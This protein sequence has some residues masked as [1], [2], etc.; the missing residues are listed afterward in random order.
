[1]RGLKTWG[2]VISVASIAILLTSGGCSLFPK[3]TEYNPSSILKTD[4]IEYSFAYAKRGDLIETASVVCAYMAIDKEDY[5]FEQ[6]GRQYSGI[7][8]NVGDT[9]EKG[10][11]LAELDMTEIKSELDIREQKRKTLELDVEFLSREKELMVEKNNILIEQASMTES[12]NLSSSAEIAAA[13]DIEIRDK[14]YELEN[15]NNEI[16][17]LRADIESGRLYARMDGTVTYVKEITSASTT[18]GGARVV[19]IGDVSNSYF[20]GSSAKKDIL[21]PGFEGI[22]D[23]D[24]DEYA[25]RVIDAEARGIEATG[26]DV[27]FEV[28]GE[29]YT[30]N[31]GDKGTLEIELNHLTNVVYVPAEAVSALGD[32]T[33]VFY[34]NDDGIRTYKEV[35]TGVTLNKQT[36]II[37]GVEDG[38]QLIIG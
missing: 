36:Q 9:V 30:L 3:E 6:D 1:M 18:V 13:Y 4:T 15:V 11:L 10:C 38:E 33:V 12:M 34:L 23:I 22:V 35:V 28:L 2:R 20:K 5:C 37:S 7:Y 19:T 17:M 16:E 27:Y 32:R 21:V 25:V 8:V 24:G 29:A 31:E 14:Q 26:N